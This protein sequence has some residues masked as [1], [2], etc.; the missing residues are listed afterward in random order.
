MCGVSHLHDR[1]GCS[2]SELIYE[3]KSTGL[4]RV[5]LVVEYLGWVD[6]IFISPPNNMLDSAWADA[7]LAELSEQD[8]RI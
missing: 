4:Y 6:L 3:L 5:A 8:Q 1:G 2:A 7:S